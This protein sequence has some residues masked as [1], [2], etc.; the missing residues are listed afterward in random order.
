MEEIKGCFW[1]GFRRWISGALM[2]PFLLIK[3]EGENGE[4]QVPNS[5]ALA[6]DISYSTPWNS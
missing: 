3:K 2:E 5:A 1:K 4:N 6:L